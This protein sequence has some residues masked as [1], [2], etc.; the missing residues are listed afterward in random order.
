[1]SSEMTLDS[2]LVEE[3]NLTNT[4]HGFHEVIL[5]KKKGD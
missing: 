5:T 4:N 3:R 1:M 2:R